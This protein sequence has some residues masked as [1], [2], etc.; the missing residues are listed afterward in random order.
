MQDNGKKGPGF[1]RVDDRVMAQ[2]L[3]DEMVLLD[4]R[5]ECYFQLNESAAAMWEACLTASD[6]DAVL[7]ALQTVYP[8]APLDHLRNDLQ[9]FVDDLVDQGLAERVEVA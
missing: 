2:N 3:G 5:S 7:A 9:V 4:T 1:F 6:E 8:D